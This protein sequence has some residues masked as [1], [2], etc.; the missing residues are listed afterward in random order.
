M[1]LAGA[2]LCSW[3]S[4]PAISRSDL[5]ESSIADK[6]PRTYRK[7][8]RNA[9]WLPKSFPSRGLPSGA[10]EGLLSLPKVFGQNVLALQADVGLII[11]N[12]NDWHSEVTILY[13]Q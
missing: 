1:P 4:V 2:D 11:A 9:G 8:P 5:W 3:G 10:L 12:C 6:K 7:G 13:Y